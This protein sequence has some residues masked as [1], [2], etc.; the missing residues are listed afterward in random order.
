MKAVLLAG[1]EGSRLRPYTTVL[2]KPLMPVGN[3]P[4][5]EI[6]VKQLKHYG[7]TEITFAVGY[8]NHLIETYFGDGSR[9]GVRINYLRENQPLGTAGPLTNLADFTEPIIVLNGD[10][11]T[12]L[13]L[14]KLYR[15]HCDNTADIT[16]A[17]CDK[18]VN[19]D[20]G[21]LRSDESGAVVEYI[22]KPEYSFEVSMGI[23]VFSPT[24]LGFISAGVRFDF[25]DLVDE[26]IKRKRLVKVYPFSGLWLDIGRDED[27]RIAA[28]LMKKNRS[29][30][31]PREA[32]P[33]GGDSVLGSSSV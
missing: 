29:R 2:P 8:L 6:I 14:S 13:D 1:G 16:I 33:A 23:Y 26:L 28:D 21:V 30:F 31:I 15:C 7:V 3:S 27:Y 25:P 17:T 5:A 4:I 22:E 10:I 32:V 11:L 20:L 12:D 19:I 9:W 18:K 24:V